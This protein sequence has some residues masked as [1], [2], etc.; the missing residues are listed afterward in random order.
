[1]DVIE[2]AE[3]AAAFKRVFDEQFTNGKTLSLGVK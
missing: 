2:G 1:L 3:A